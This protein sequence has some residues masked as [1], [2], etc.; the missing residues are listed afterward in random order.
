VEHAKVIVGRSMT[1]KELVWCDEVMCVTWTPIQKIGGCDESQNVGG[2]E[3]CQSMVR[4][5]SFRVCRA[6]S[7]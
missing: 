5:L 6:C 2:A 1:K 7:A 3:A 4:M